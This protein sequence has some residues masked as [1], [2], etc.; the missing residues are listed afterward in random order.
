MKDSDFVYLASEIAMA[1]LLMITVLCCWCIACCGC[2]KKKEEE[3][4]KAQLKEKLMEGGDWEEYIDLE[5]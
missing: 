2:C 3:P 5:N 4:K 1:L